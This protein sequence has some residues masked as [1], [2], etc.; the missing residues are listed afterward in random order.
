MEI[1]RPKLP[2][3]CRVICVSDIHANCEKFKKLLEKCQYNQDKDFLFIL[4]DIVEKGRDN[5]GTV[6]FVMELCRGPK[7]VCIKGNNDT[8]CDR[9]A[10]Y[11]SK[12]RFLE[13]I[14]TRPHNTFTEMGKNIGIEDFNENFEEKRK[15]VID[16]FKDELEFMRALPLAIETNEHIFIHAGIENRPDWENTSEKFALTQ[17][18]Y[19]RLEHSSPKTVVCG[20]YPTYNYRRANNTCLPIFDS[21]RRMICID[22]GASTKCA[23]QLNALIVNYRGEGFDYETVYVPFGEEKTVVRPVSSD[24]T[25]VYVDWEN[26]SLTVIEKQNDFL[27]VQI[28]QTGERGLIPESR[29]GSWDGKLHGWT[30]LGAFLSARPNERFYVNGE[31]EEYY[32]G[33]DENA[34]VGF[35]PKSCFFSKDTDTKG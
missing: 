13:R 10:F 32:L 2:Q 18:W 6:H 26:H 1:I 30:H 25:P 19:L 34:R 35:L 11:D 5:L 21:E 16:A 7:A 23:A 27:Y 12:E 29:T 31:T 22:G 9:M 8:M 15:R 24:Y 3:D 14:K 4:G 17:P 20:H 28:D 33:I